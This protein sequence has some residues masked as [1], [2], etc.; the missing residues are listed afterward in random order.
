MSDKTETK[1]WLEQAFR[2]ELEELNRKDP[3]WKDRFEAAV[4]FGFDTARI[5]YPEPGQSRLRTLFLQVRVWL[6]EGF[7]IRPHL[8]S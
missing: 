4:L 8:K 3:H 7:W 5:R 2:E 1:A 6:R